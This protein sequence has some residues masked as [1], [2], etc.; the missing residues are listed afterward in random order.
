MTAVC[1]AMTVVPANK[2]TAGGKIS[3]GLFLSPNVKAY[4]FIAPFTASGIDRRE[5]NSESA[6]CALR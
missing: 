4:A 6:C 5:N 1:A 3:G 2:E